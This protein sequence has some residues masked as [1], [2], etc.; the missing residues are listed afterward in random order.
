[1]IKNV[2]ARATQGRVPLVPTAPAALPTIAPAGS[3]PVRAA[4]ADA[5]FAATAIII[6]ALVTISAIG[7]WVILDRRADA[8]RPKG[9]QSVAQ[10]LANNSAASRDNPGSGSAN[11]PGAGGRAE[12]IRKQSVSSPSTESLRVPAQ[13]D[14]PSETP[15]T[16][17]ASPSE[18]D[19]EPN[20]VVVA[21]SDAG[22]AIAPG[23]GA[24]ASGARSAVSA[25]RAGDSREGRS[26]NE[27][28]YGAD[29]G[30]VIPPEFIDPYLIGM[31]LRTSPGLR[32]DVL[33]IAVT[34][35]KQGRVDAV[36]AMSEPRNIGES[37]MLT[38]ALSAV[39]TW[40]FRPA[41]REGVPVKYREIIP[42]SVVTGADRRERPEV[43]LT[44][45][46]P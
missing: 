22:G 44:R 39:K 3:S 10:P 2:Y 42:V 14:S 1:M 23:S 33:T 16:S 30:E 35:N 8:R 34:V 31:L 19:A 43:P 32:Q 4:W 26:A 28:I 40:R 17:P 21:R 11:N 36:R 9:A 27:I 45:P 7:T 20:G 46:L 12:S 41:I 29:N 15:G 25:N 18:Q 38:G 13:G 24:S 37:M 6:I 5:R